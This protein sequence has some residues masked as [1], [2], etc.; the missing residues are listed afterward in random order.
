MLGQW[1]A[2]PHLDKDCY[3]NFD[4]SSGPQRGLGKE[5]FT[6]D[7]FVPLPKVTTL[8]KKNLLSPPLNFA[9]LMAY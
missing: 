5:E 6:V 7:L 3:L 2:E 1:W 8:E 4:L 9:F